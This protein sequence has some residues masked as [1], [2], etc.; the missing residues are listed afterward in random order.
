MLS[1]LFFFFINI[2]YCTIPSQ[3]NILRDCFKSNKP[4][5][6]LDFTPQFDR[7]AI[8][9]EVNEKCTTIEEILRVFSVFIW[10]Y[11][12]KFIFYN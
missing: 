5:T 4:R 12:I 3:M 11:Q 10:L 2:N 1:A 8:G 9:S 6:H 7:K